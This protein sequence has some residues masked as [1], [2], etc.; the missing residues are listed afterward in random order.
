MEGYVE[1]HM[2]DLKQIQSVRMGVIFVVG[3]DVAYRM[4]TLPTTSFW[5]RYF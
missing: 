4:I 1:N 5:G 3:Y 2:L